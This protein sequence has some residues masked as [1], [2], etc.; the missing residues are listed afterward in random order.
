MPLPKGHIPWNKNRI[1]RICKVCKKEFFVNLFRV[2]AGK[3]KHC[4]RKCLGIARKK[5]INGKKNPMYDK[6]YSRKPWSKYSDD[7][8]NKCVQKYLQGESSIK[9][10]SQVNCCYALIL[11]WVRK[12]KGEKFIRGSPKDPQPFIDKLTEIEK[13]YITGLIDGEGSIYISLRAH[14]NGNRIYCFYVSVVNTYKEIIEYLKNKLN[15]SIQYRKARDIKN[16][17]LWRWAIGGVGT[18]KIIEA[19]FPYFIIKKEQAKI[20]LQFHKEQFSSSKRKFELWQKMRFLN[21]KGK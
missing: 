1:K 6:H 9:I 8:Q 12:R 2:K 17:D 4:S 14:P 21:K 11:K 19:L 7:F 5:M 16:K 3:D 18:I 20:I 13:A 10:A 15:G